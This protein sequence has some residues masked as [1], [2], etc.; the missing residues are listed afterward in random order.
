MPTPAIFGTSAATVPAE[1][2]AVAVAVAAAAP[3]ASLRLQFAGT[4]SFG[5]V[6]NVGKLAVIESHRNRDNCRLAQIHYLIFQR[7]P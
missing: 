5:I 6:I 4:K 2:R 1:A 7:G 3:T